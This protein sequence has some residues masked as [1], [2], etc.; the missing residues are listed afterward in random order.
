[1]KCTDLKKGKREGFRI[2]YFYNKEE[3]EILWLLTLYGKM[4]EENISVN[5]IKSLLKE[6]NLL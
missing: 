1:M 3:K 4:D 2:I 5:H 6:N